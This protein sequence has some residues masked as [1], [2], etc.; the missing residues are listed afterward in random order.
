MKFVF[1]AFMCIFFCACGAVNPYQIK[2]VSNNNTSGIVV[3]S[4]D[5]EN[6]FIGNTRQTT[7]YIRS[8]NG[9][10]DFQLEYGSKTSKSLSGLTRL[11]FINFFDLPA[12]EYEIYFWRSSC[13]TGLSSW[14][15]ESGNEFSVPFHIEAEKLNYLGQLHL[16]NDHTITITDESDR[17]IGE[18]LN[19]YPFL[20]EVEL[21]QCGIFG[22]TRALA[23]PNEKSK[24]YLVV[25]VQ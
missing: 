6:S 14:F 5:D 25:P 4:V 7:F 21:A 16:G 10:I 23:E 11:G 24:A 20:S 22:S 19:R 1:L 18:L 9:K 3:V 17:D 8:K 13:F 12:G 15:E 2:N